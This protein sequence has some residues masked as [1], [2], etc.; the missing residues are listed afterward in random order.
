MDQDHNPCQSW[1][2]LTVVTNGGMFPTKKVW[3]CKKKSSQMKKRR[4]KKWNLRWFCFGS[5]IISWTSWRPLEPWWILCRH[6]T[7]Q[8]LFV[9]LKNSEVN[10]SSPKLVSLTL[11]WSFSP[12]VSG[13]IANVQTTQPIQIVMRPRPGCDPA[14]FRTDLRHSRGWRGG[15]SGEKKQ[16]LS[17]RTSIFL[18]NKLEIAW[19]VC[20]TR[21]RDPLVLKKKCIGNT[22]ANR[23]GPRIVIM[24]RF[25]RTNSSVWNFVNEM[26]MKFT[27]SERHTSNKICLVQKAAATSVWTMAPSR[28][29]CGIAQAP[30]RTIRPSPPISPHP[31]AWYSRPETPVF[32]KK[33]FVERSV[34]TTPAVQFQFS[35]PIG[36]KWFQFQ[37][38][39]HMA[40]RI[41]LRPSERPSKWNRSNESQKIPGRSLSAKPKLTTHEQFC[42]DPAS[43]CI[44]SA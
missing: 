36:F 16:Y 39:Q 27:K 30:T 12:G 9:T 28:N 35:K 41:C 17:R 6:G 7:C 5:M 23:K 10:S 21:P 29:C 25:K 38:G 42:I 26:C 15:D 3:W 40:L 32:A 4:G 18:D 13:Q 34:E 24:R 20:Q 1:I 37:S 22:T 14:E 31:Q 8:L 43:K 44:C 33:W 2:Q 11:T 19:L